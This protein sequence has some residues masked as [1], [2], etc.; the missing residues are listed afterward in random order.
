MMRTALLLARMKF[1]F[2]VSFHIILPSFTIWL[3]AWLHGARGIPLDHR[4]AGLSALWPFLILFTS[5]VEQAAPPP[6]NPSFMLW[7]RRAAYPHLH[8]H[9]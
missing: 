9:V 4:Q 2:R 8:R 5:T 7:G 6:A 1:D 3:A